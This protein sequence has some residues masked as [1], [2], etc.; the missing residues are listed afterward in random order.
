MIAF[1]STERQQQRQRDA[2]RAARR[3]KTLENLRRDEASCGVMRPRPAAAVMETAS[4]GRVDLPESAA[5]RL[6]QAESSLTMADVLRAFSSEY[7]RRHGLSMTVQQ[8]RVLREMAACYTPL[9]GTHEWTCDDC[10]TVVEL[11]N[12]CSN[13]HCPTCGDANRHK[14]AETT[15]SQILPVEY[16]HVILTVPRQIT[17]LALAH[18]RVLYPIMLRSGAGRGS[19]CRL[20][21]SK[22]CW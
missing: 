13:R 1:A 11:P 22:S 3:D 8:D 12:S 15:A 21:R 19:I 9:M 20:S 6:P 14:W 4:L 17:Q 7:R 2:L 16:Y 10:G 5:D 18:P